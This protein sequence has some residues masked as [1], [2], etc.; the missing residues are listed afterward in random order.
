MLSDQC[1]MWTF[2]Y[3]EI[4]VCL[5]GNHI[6]H[7]ARLPWPSWLKCTCLLQW[8]SYTLLQTLWKRHNQKTT[9]MTGFILM[10][11]CTHPG[12]F[13]LYKCTLS[14]TNATCKSRMTL[15]LLVGDALRTGRGLDFWK[16][17]VYII[18]L[19]HDIV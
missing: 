7:K 15:T 10:C 18:T 14:I 13:T 9:R 5:Q 8:Q 2:F 4:Y 12:Y 3:D 6:W 11:K 1:W 17:L 19:L 16:R